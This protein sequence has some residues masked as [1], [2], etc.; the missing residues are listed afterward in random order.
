MAAT[1]SSARSPAHGSDDPAPEVRAAVRDVLLGTPA[2]REMDPEQRRQL[3]QGMVRICHAAAM[4]QREEQAGR[5]WSG[6]DAPDTSQAARPV[7]ATA[8][9]AAGGFGASADRAVD[10]TRRVLNAVSF[11][12]FVTDL[13]NGVFKAMLDS[14]IAQIHAYVDLIN[15]VSASVEGFTDANMGADSARSWLVERYPDAFELNRDDGDDGNPVVTVVLKDT[16]TMPSEAALRTDLGLRADESP[17]GGDPEALVPFVR[18]HLARTRQQVLATLVTLGLQRIVVDSGRINAAMRF[19][20]DTR[21]AAADD[22]G[23]R[24]ESQTGVHAH[25]QGGMGLW[26]ASADVTENIGYVSTQ[27]EQSTEEMNTDLDLNSSVEV[28]FRGEPVSL[29]RLATSSQVQAIR[30][31]TRNPEAED[32][33]AAQER[34]QRLAAQRQAEQ[35]R[36]QGLDDA[37]RPTPAPAAA[38]APAAAHP[39]AAG[40][41]Q[42]AAGGAHT[43][44]TAGGTPPAAG[45][46]GQPA[47]AGA[48]P[49][50]SGTTPPAA[51]AGQP[52]TGGAQPPPATAATHS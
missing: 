46:G 19:H 6:G 5:E 30:A 10:T 39:P 3:A 23:S 37:L 44:T 24:F 27:R 14:S 4:L 49:P 50:A 32:Q 43:G 11:P 9:A 35:Q 34:S 52:A 42:P 18:Q 45:G 8:Q 29:D 41:A 20:V 15:N 7:L 40:G 2:Y 38:A 26:S 13:L 48:H 47:A 21:S 25:A 51:G 17:P 16:G 28:T 33:A 22:R 31:N 1:S 36:R 12:R